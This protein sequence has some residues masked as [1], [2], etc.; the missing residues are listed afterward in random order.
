MEEIANCLRCSNC[1]LERLTPGLIR[2]LRLLIRYPNFDGVPPSEE[3]YTSFI[4]DLRIF[5]G[6]N[7][8]SELPMDL[9]KLSAI[10]EISPRRNKLEEIPTAIKNLTKLEKLNVSRNYLTSFPWELLELMKKGT[11]KRFHPYR[12]PFERLTPSSDVREWCCRNPAAVQGDLITSTYDS[13]E[14]PGST[15]PVLVAIGHVQF[16]DGEGNPVEEPF[17]STLLN[18]IANKSTRTGTK[19]PSLF[20]HALR[21]FGSS[22]NCAE[23]LHPSEQSDLPEHVL[24]L[25]RKAAEANKVGGRTCNVCRKPYI[26]AMAE[27]KEWW[28]CIPQETEMRRRPNRCLRPLP[29]LRRA[30]SWHCAPGGEELLKE[31]PKG[32]RR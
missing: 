17:E 18:G 19:V 7:L 31:M 14:L 28:D 16:F 6:C 26:V 9:F 23:L 27:W 12:N 13:T 4:P 11:L 21:T 1:N 8:L 22:S 25:M 15:A 10:K 2:S 32:R 24:R 3:L 29:F 20:A 30:C 5:L